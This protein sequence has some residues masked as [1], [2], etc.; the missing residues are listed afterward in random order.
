MDF[1]QLSWKEWA[2]T[3]WVCQQVVCSGGRFTK[4]TWETFSWVVIF[5]ARGGKIWSMIRKGNGWRI[6]IQIALDFIYLV[7][8]WFCSLQWPQIAPTNQAVCSECYRL[9]CWQQWKEAITGG[10]PGSV[11]R[12]RPSQGE[13]SDKPSDAALTASRFE[14]PPLCLPGKKTKPS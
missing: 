14:P 4:K 12:D 2:A 7:F 3:K 13:T 6:K 9:C 5:R 8:W 1:H 11:A 10:S